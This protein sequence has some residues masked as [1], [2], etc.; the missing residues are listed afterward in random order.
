MAYRDRRSGFQ[1][2]FAVEMVWRVLEVVCLHRP[3][4]CQPVRGASSFGAALAF[5]GSVMQVTF[6]CLLRS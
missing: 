2:D 5:G 6:E 3:V 1:A 4:E